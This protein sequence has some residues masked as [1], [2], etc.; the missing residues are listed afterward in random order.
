MINL[1]SS[2]EIANIATKI[3]ELTKLV[4]WIHT[5]AGAGLNAV[6]E[7]VDDCFSGWPEH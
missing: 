1:S 2:Y 7:E 6:F 3:Q 4:L 5:S